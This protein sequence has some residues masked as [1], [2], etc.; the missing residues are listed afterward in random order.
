MKGTDRLILVVLPMVA[1]A[2][3][4]WLLVL[5]PKGKE[6]AELQ[7][8]ID[9][10]Q[11]TI[12]T[13][14]TQIATSEKARAAFPRNYAEVVSLGAA[15]PENDD[16]ASLIQSFR[17]L[18][19]QESVAFHSFKLVPGSGV[20]AP[21]APAITD[22]VEPSATDVSGDAPTT[23]VAVPATEADAASLP[24]G[25]TVGPAG[26]PVTPYQLSYSGS[27]FDVADLLDDISSS[28]D[29]G[30]DP[31]RIDVKAHGRLMTVDGFVLTEDPKRLFPSVS[32]GL[33]VTTYLVPEGQG[34]A[35]GATPAGPA[36]IGSPDAPTTVT[37]TATTS[38]AAT[39]AAV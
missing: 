32:A 9:T 7:A 13:A 19:L 12:D 36:A 15:V 33:N 14:E 21:A 22:P 26:L 27:F 6:A 38:P 17:D 4:F 31:G 34:I 10:A 3:G 25:A 37:D 16:Q 2:I 23:P 5:A 8:R 39:S 30:D 20:T 11:T 1:L 18:A 28:V 29:V 24:I 35:A